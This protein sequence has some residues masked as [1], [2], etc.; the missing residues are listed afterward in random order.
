MN[1][2]AAP[3]VFNFRGFDPTSSTSWLTWA[4]GNCLGEFMPPGTLAV[5]DTSVAPRSG[6]LAL[7]R[8]HA[9]GMQDSLSVKQLERVNGVWLMLSLD[10][11]NELVPDRC[12]VLGKI[13]QIVKYP[14]GWVRVDP[15]HK[16][17]FDSPVPSPSFIAY[18]R[19]MQRQIMPRIE[20]YGWDRAAVYG[21]H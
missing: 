15:W 3:E 20:R 18:Q 1:T 7:I 6:D 4:T 19:G 2:R 5:F 9:P 17:D 8:L 14:P 12:E 13:V 10:G 16:D 11:W 21:R